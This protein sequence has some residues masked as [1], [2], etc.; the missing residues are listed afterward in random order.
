MIGVAYGWPTEFRHNDR[1]VPEDEMPTW[2]PDMIGEAIIQDDL[3]VD[4]TFAQ[5]L[6]ATTEDFGAMLKNAKYKLWYANL[7]AR[8]AL[9]RGVPATLSGTPKYN[10]HANDF[11]IEAD[12]IGLMAPGLPESAN[13]LCMRAGRVINHGDGIYGGMFVSGMYAAAY[14]ETDP[15][16]IVEA[17]LACMPAKSPYALLIKDTL[18]WSKEN[19][20]DWIKTWQMLEDKWNKREPCPSGALRPFNIDAKINGAYIALGLLYGDGDFK[21]TMEISTRCGKDSDCNPANACGILGVA[22]GYTGIPEEYKSGIPAVADQKFSFT[23]F[24]FRT[25]VD[26]SHKRAIAL[27]KSQG[28]HVVGDKLVVRLQKPVPPKLDVWDDYGTPV[29]NILVR[30]KRWHWDGP[31]EETVAQLV[32]EGKP[33]GP[34]SYGQLASQKGAEGTGAIVVGPF[35]G[36]GGKAEVYLDGNLDRTIDVY[37]GEPHRK[38]HE[39]VWHAFGLKNGKHTVRVVVLGQTYPG[40]TGSDIAIER[41]LVFR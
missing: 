22:M 28:G 29:E 39:A 23:N 36:T 7:G 37:P 4:M 41:L 31:W 9:Q 30:D 11:Q 32:L 3:Y 15:R 21:K 1:L 24:T 13:D 40:S 26:S 14:F 19:P 2:K 6:D 25:I 38:Y 20:D 10:A 18:D 16:K 17:G 12:F 5:G 27:V 8:R 35:L 33:R 34:K